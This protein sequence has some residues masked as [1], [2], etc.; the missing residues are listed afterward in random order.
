MASTAAEAWKFPNVANINAPGISESPY[1]LF[2]ILAKQA[3]L[4]VQILMLPARDD[5]NSRRISW[6]ESVLWP[7]TIQNLKVEKEEGGKASIRHRIRILFCTVCLPVLGAIVVAHNCI[8]YAVWEDI[9]LSHYRSWRKPRI[10]R[11]R[12]GSTTAFRVLL[13]KMLQSK[14]DCGKFSFFRRYFHQP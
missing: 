13:R 1:L 12:P 3:A 4:N 7:S 6:A 8:L 5:N 9:I 14:L 10:S 2:L 11:T